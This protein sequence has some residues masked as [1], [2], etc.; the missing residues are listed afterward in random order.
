MAPTAEGSSPYVPPGVYRGRLDEYDYV[1]EE[2][3]AIGEAA[4]RAYA[5]TVLV[6]RP[7]DPARFS[8]TVITEPLHAMGATPI[9]MYTSRFIMGSG[10]GWA[11]ITSQKTALD[12]H[13]KP[14]DPQRY[15]SRHIE[16]DP[17]SPDA[18]EL[19]VFD[20]P[21]GDPAKMAAFRT[22]MQ[23]RNSASST[24]LAQVGAA[25]A[26]SGGSFEGWDVAHVLLAGHSQT[27][28]VVTDFIREGHYSHRRADGSAV[29][30]GYFPSGA[31]AEPFAGCEVP[32]VQV[33][34]EGDI[35]DPSRPGP[36][37]PRGLHRQYRR[38][39]SD[40]PGDRY[41]LYELAGVAHMGTRYPPYNDPST[42]QQVTT[43]GAVP[44]GAR[45]NSLP[46]DELFGLG[47]HHLVQWV[48]Q[49]ITPPR[50]ERIEVGPD[51]YFAKDEHGNSLGGIRPVHLDVPTARYYANPHGDDGSPGFGVVGTEQPFDL[52]KLRRLYPDHR[53]YIGRFNRRLDQLIDEGWFLEADAAGLRD[54]ADAAKVLDTAA[55]SDAEIPRATRRGRVP[56]ARGPRP[57][58]P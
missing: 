11:M 14:V 29:F 31:P 1:E 6:R 38:A 51:G 12:M 8:G 33:L 27:G 30:D 15:A 56:R 23:R 4:G 44:L 13:V 43:A 18:P 20:L 19:D 10:H 47:L 40:D 24:I 39:D 5:T 53:A 48:A 42:W 46:H 32:I 36:L 52:D 3:S 25:I 57:E 49:D 50:A 28:G 34:S 9:W 17:P 16:A 55:Q 41:R 37:G 7:Q 22:E 21:V 58:G 54:E 35:A 26:A 45:M 2:W